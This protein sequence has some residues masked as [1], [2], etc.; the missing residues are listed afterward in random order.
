MKRNIIARLRSRRWWVF[1]T[2]AILSVNGLAA[3]GSSPTES[4][5]VENQEKE[6]PEDKK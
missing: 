2:L 4:R 3:C 5:V 1:A 6:T